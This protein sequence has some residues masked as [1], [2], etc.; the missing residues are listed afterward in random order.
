M[1]MLSCGGRRELSEADQIKLA[2]MSPFCHFPLAQPSA[3]KMEFPLDKENPALRDAETQEKQASLGP[4]PGHLKRA[5][6]P[7]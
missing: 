3:A 6:C 7:G 2:E 1:E 4:F 5:C